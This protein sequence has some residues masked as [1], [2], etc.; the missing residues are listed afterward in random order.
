MVE[1]Y[2]W[3]SVSNIMEPFKQFVLTQEIAQ[4]HIDTL[5]DK[6]K[7]LLT[8]QKL[9]FGHIF[10]SD[11]QLRIIEPLKNKNKYKVKIEELSGDYVF[12]WDQW[13]G[14]KVS[15]DLKKNPTK[16]GK[17]LN[18]RRQELSKQLK[19]WEDSPEEYYNIKTKIDELDELLKVVDLQK[20]T[21]TQTQESFY[22]VYSRSP[23]DV[24]RMSDFSG[25]KSCHSQDGS[26]FYCAVADA[27]L[28]AGIAYLITE[29]SY[30]KLLQLDDDEPW[31]MSEIFH[32][33]Q[34]RVYTHITPVA[35]IRLRL[36]VD[37]EGNQLCVPQTKIYGENVTK[38]EK[39]F[40]S[41]VIEWAKSQDVSE[42]D[43]SNTLSL[44][45]G[46]YEDYGVDIRNMVKLI[47]G[48]YIDYTTDSTED[49]EYNMREEHVYDEV[50]EE[51]DD[52]EYEIITSILGED[53]E[54]M[55]DIHYNIDF[56]NGGTMFSFVLPNFFTSQDAYRNG[57]R[58]GKTIKEV[59]KSSLKFDTVYVKGGRESSYKLK[60]RYVEESDVVA[61]NVEISTSP[62]S[63]YFSYYGGY[64]YEMQYDE[65]IEAVKDE[66]KRSLELLFGDY[67]IA[68]YY[69]F[70]IKINII[71]SICEFLNIDYNF[72]F[73]DI[74]LFLEY[75]ET[76]EFDSYY[77]LKE[78][79]YI[80]DNG[81]IT[82][83]DYG[84]FLKPANWAMQ[85]ILE[86]FITK[87]YD[88]G[89]DLFDF[90][91]SKNLIRSILKIPSSETIHRKFVSDGTSFGDK[92]FVRADN[93]IK[94][95]RLYPIL[96]FR[97]FEEFSELAY[98]A[99]GNIASALKELIHDME[100]G[101]LDDKFDKSFE[102]FDKTIENRII[103]AGDQLMFGFDESVE[104]YL[105][106]S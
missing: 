93:S 11:D 63:H 103:D 66:L 89:K 13:K 25:M 96:D 99:D 6:V 1:F 20:Q 31:N 50:V 16:I 60:L 70:E 85:D 94:I 92:I 52:K 5:N 15:D 91:Y 3:R 64:E 106:I 104:Y 95:P 14:Y 78:L 19:T 44:M 46:S 2:L 68:E 36:V 101:D 54:N 79:D 86:L 41:Q 97:D 27:T 87:N 24:L 77:E 43:W 71:S 72:K 58:V 81:N 28:N 40:K 9:P 76:F 48:K 10:G 55:F 88:H 69:A 73:E 32:D 18:R 83:A 8:K 61:V 80:V 39:D 29:T 65:C 23:I 75:L 21:Q 74:E 51:L 33:S 38:F 17:L 53:F 56:R 4:Y 49:E 59:I 105:T 12:D 30:N 100:E 22:I 67:T 45:G 82:V 7:K 84:S 57:K 42:F 47:W 90:L 98:Y 62:A 37:D 34:R 35:R 26:Y 102:N